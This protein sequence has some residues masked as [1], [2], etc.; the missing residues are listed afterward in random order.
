MLTSGLDVIIEYLQKADAEG[1]VNLH[2]QAIP[3]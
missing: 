1:G 2:E 3:R